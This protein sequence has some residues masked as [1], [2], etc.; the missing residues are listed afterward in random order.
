MS[1]Y[2]WHELHHVQQTSREQ[3][4]HIVLPYSGLDGEMVVAFVDILA[5]RIA[6]RLTAEFLKGSEISVAKL[7][8]SFRNKSP[9]SKLSNFT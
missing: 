7:P 4:H 3:T 9:E 5:D 6:V 8:K 2:F 1:L